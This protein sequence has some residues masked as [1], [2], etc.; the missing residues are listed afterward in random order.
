M[1]KLILLLVVVSLVVLI[2]NFTQ[3]ETTAPA[4]A[5]PAYYVDGRV[6]PN[7]HIVIGQVSVPTGP[8]QSPSTA[9]GPPEE[10]PVTLS[11][12]ATFTSADSYK[13]FLSQPYGMG[14]GGVVRIIDGSHFV[15]RGGRSGPAWQQDFF[16]IGN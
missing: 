12:A 4:A 14:S 16:C 15:Y 10:F 11:H 6:V 13:C 8:P 3:A 2:I 7:A 1:R 5:A 9:P